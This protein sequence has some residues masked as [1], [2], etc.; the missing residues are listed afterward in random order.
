M[1]FYILDIIRYNLILRQAKEQGLKFKALI[2]HG[3][4]YG[5]A[6]KL[7]DAIGRMLIL[8]TMLIRIN[9]AFKP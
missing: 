5:V 8:S 2:G 3:A 4:G 9:M 1:L 6:D 7:F